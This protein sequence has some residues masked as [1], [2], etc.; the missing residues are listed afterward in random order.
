MHCHVHFYV[1]FYEY[2]PPMA[3][4]SI[5]NF[6]AGVLWN[7]YCM[8][9][10]TLIMVADYDGKNKFHWRKLDYEWT[11][12]TIYFVLTSLAVADRFSYNIDRR[13]GYQIGIGDRLG[14]RDAGSDYVSAP[15]TLQM[16]T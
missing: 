16:S 10:C 11:V 2:V 8:M 9:M 1:C 13:Q 3:L 7:T 15:D 5:V 4:T 12:W 14:N 6:N